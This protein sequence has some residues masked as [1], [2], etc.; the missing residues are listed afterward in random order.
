MD[1]EEK[2]AMD[3]EEKADSEMRVPKPPAPPYT[4]GAR[5]KDAPPL[6]LPAEEL[7]ELKW[8]LWRL[9]ETDMMM[10]MKMRRSWRR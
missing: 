9:I 6:T 3:P 8:R 10:M 2:G 5:L 1:P 4:L 7:R